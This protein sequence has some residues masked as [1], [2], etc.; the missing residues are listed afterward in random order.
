MQTAQFEAFA[1][2]NTKRNGKSKTRLESGER[3]ERLARVAFKAKKN[4][5]R[6]EG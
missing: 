1:K 4:A 3:I 5:Q 2:T 6:F